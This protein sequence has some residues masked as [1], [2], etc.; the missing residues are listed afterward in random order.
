MAADSVKL[1]SH[2]GREPTCGMADHLQVE[3]DPQAGLLPQAGVDRGTLNQFVPASRNPTVQGS[4]NAGPVTAASLDAGPAGA[5]PL[6]VSGTSL[7]GWVATRFGPAVRGSTPWYRL[8]DQARHRTAPVVIT[9]SGELRAGSS[10]LAEFGRSSD[11]AAA[12]TTLAAIPLA[13][14]PGAPA[15]RDVRM[16]VPDAAADLVRLSVTAQREPGAVPLSFSPP[17]TPHPEPMNTVLPPGTEAVV[18][19]PVA[20]MYPC[21]KIAGTPNGTAALPQWRVGTPSSDKSGDIITAPQT[22]G[23]FT[24]ARSLVRAIRIPVYLN[25]DPLRDILTISR[26]QPLTSFSRPDISHGSEVIDGWRHHGHLHVP[27]LNQHDQ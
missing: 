23:P 26:W 15:S 22:G 1:L 6:E 13:D 4:D 14:Q 7:P 16:I 19:W 17:R 27:P 18:D 20:F 12:M 8:D 24:T 2:F 21:L 11:D 5:V 9:I 10:L 3:T 25:A